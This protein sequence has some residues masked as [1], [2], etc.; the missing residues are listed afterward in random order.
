MSENPD[1][2]K[3]GHILDYRKESRGTG[4]IGC[5][6]F[7]IV[8]ATG[9]AGMLALTV[10]SLV[11][12]GN[13]GLVSTGLFLAIGTFGIVFWV[14]KIKVGESAASAIAI[15]SVCVFLL[16]FGTCMAVGITSAH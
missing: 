8:L 2:S 11:T 1:P 10:F 16:M 13:V 4:G 12:S 5:L 9:V 14:I 3:Q 6:V 15:I 7:S